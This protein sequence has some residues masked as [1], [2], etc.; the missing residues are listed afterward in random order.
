MRE[1]KPVPLLSMIC[2]GSV[3]DSGVMTQIIY[4]L[5][6]L[7]QAELQDLPSEYQASHAVRAGPVLC[8]SPRDAQGKGLK[9]G[10]GCSLP[11]CRARFTVFLQLVFGKRTESRIWQAAVCLKMQ[12]QRVLSAEQRRNRP[13]K[14]QKET[15]NMHSSC[16]SGR[17]SVGKERT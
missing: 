12:E 7:L 2:S 3:Q 14:G 15:E 8:R 6:K 1:E 10:A 5:T 11:G 13:H 9:I 16:L 4:M 17:Y